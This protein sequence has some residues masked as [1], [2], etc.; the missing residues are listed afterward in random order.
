MK[1]RIPRTAVEAVLLEV[2]GG[3]NPQT[4]RATIR[5]ALTAALP[6]LPASTPAGRAVVRAAVAWWRG[7]RPHAW[8]EAQHA[9]SPMIGMGRSESA[10]LARAVG[11]YMRER[12]KARRTKR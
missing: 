8:S 6:H 3:W 2:H 1:P 5:E 10:D 11:R 7:N 4:N 9:D 12:A